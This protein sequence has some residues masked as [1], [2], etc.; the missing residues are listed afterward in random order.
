MKQTGSLQ[1]NDTIE[2]EIT[3]YSSEGSGV[4]HYNG[5]AVFVNGAAAGDT[6]ECVVIKAK[7]NYAVGKLVHILKASQDRVSPDCGAFPRC[8]GCQYRHISYDAELR[9]KQQK[10]ADA[11]NRIGHIS[12]V[13]D[14]IV[15]TEAPERYRNKAQYP[16]CMENGRLS[17]GFYAPFSH[18]VIDGKDCLLQ[19][20]SF[21]AILRAVARWAEKYKIP[22]YDESTGKG[23][24]RHVYIRKGFATN[25]TMVCLVINGEKIYQPEALLA[26]L[27]KA[28]L[29]VKTVLLNHNTE[30]TNVILGRRC[31]V[32]Y[33]GGYIED[34]LCGKR[35]RLS[36]LSFY[37]VNHDQAQ[38]LY[39][40]AAGFAAG[41]K[42][43]LD[44]YCGAGTIGLTMA[45]KVE[46]LIGVEIVPEAVADAKVNAALNGVTNAEFLCA[47]AA[48]AAKTLKERGLLPDTV[49]LDPPRKG[50]DESLI[51]TLAE[52]APKRIVYVSCDPATLARDCARLAEEGYEVKQA[53]P[54]DLFPRTVHVETVC[55]LYHQKKEFISVPY[56]PK[57]AD[58]LNKG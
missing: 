17:A 37:Q 36:P 6:A 35:F 50:C 22:T 34:I 33:G 44:L 9:L 42:T 51:R 38:R 2:L 1:K 21:G 3:G 32:L 5:Q 24:L 54:F 13:P 28:D 39:E 8:G 49:I 11:L 27:L 18:R 15:G 25:E 10:V 43:L 45:D 55:L 23:L 56:E 53:V 40:K 30:K 19:P 46:R 31:T 14:P 7:P 16:V 57:D 26:A 41:A 29:S 58:Y 48:Q 47:D 52:M 20:E 12:V 4:G